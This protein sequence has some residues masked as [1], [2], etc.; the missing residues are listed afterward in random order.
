MEKK[1]KKLDYK[2]DLMVKYKKL[3]DERFDNHQIVK[4][5]PDM[6]SIVDSANMAAHLQLSVA[7]SQ[8][9]DSN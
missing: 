5:I 8:G 2:L 9:S 4:L 1:K 6:K 3:V 7:E